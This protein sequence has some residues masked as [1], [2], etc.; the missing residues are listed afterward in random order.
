MVIILVCKYLHTAICS[1]LSR[2]CFGVFNNISELT[3]MKL[4]DAV[5]AVVQWRMN[6]LKTDVWR[7]YYYAEW[8][9]ASAVFRFPLNIQFCI[10]FIDELSKLDA[11]LSDYFIAVAF[12][13]LSLIHI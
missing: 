1:K 11:S 9:I 12:L 4:D 7:A 6:T 5:S 8:R 13:H 2:E 10:C 3:D